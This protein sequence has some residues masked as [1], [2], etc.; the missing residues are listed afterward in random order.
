[1]SKFATGSQSLKD[2]SKGADF[3]R[4][5][6]F[7]IDDGESAIV[8][9]LT[10]YTETA[11]HVGAWIT[12]DQHGHVP[13]RPKP[14][15]VK[16]DARWPEHF[17]V[18]CRNT[19]CKGLP[20][21][22][23]LWTVMDDKD[24]PD[25]KEGC[26]VCEMRSSD[27][28]PYRA[29]SRGWALGCLREEVRGD[30]SPE[31]GGEKMKGKVVGYIDKTR[32]VERDGNVVSEKAIVVFNMGW[33]NFF[34]TLDGFGN[35][36]ETILDRD[37]KITRAGSGVDTDYQI[38]P[39]DPVPGPDGDRYDLREKK[40]MDRYPLSATLDEVVEEQ[41]AHVYHRRWFDPSYTPPKKKDDEKS[42]GGGS[43]EEEVQK[44][45]G[46]AS[47]DDMQ[48][49]ADRVMG[50]Y[51][52]DSDDSADSSGDTGSEKAQPGLQFLG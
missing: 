7:K 28:K 33:K 51:G 45:S 1:M 34:G 40:Y 12:V 36:Y 30:G 31:K 46:D 38:V 39:M 10:D 11:E 47:A 44:P 25:G 26:L 9:F 23:P 29:A 14:D 20:G 8:R 16:K 52:G 48:A 6:Y 24:G 37:Y 13:T 19:K 41:A 4:T 42:D 3:A 18:V 50:R 5:H 21:E 35:H 32:E 15:W 17:G 2:A 43:S 49:M 22:P 27:N